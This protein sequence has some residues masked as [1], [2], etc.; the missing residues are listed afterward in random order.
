MEK[1][2]KVAI[3]VAACITTLVTL[4]YSRSLH[5]VNS[6]DLAQLVREQGTQMKDMDGKPLDKSYEITKFVSGTE[7]YDSTNVHIEVRDCLT[8]AENGR[9]IGRMKIRVDPVNTDM[10]HHL[11]FRYEITDW[12]CD[13]MKTDFDDFRMYLGRDRWHHARAKRNL[14]EPVFEPVIQAGVRP[15]YDELVKTLHEELSKRE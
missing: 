15:M 4:A 9:I 11:P 3:R 1:K 6:Q 2:D 8:K 10:A 14:L 12:S 5:Q 13:G 7:E